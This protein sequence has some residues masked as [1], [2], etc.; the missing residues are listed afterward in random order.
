[1]SLLGSNFLVLGQLT[2]FSILEKCSC[3][4][5][6]RIA[7]EE[8]QTLPSIMSEIRSV[9]VLPII[10]K[11]RTIECRRDREGVVDCHQDDL[12]YK[13]RLKH[14][15]LPQDMLETLIAN[16]YGRLFKATNDKKKR[17]GVNSQPS[18]VKSREET[19][20]IIVLPP[21]QSDPPK[22]GLPTKI[23][24]LPKI[25]KNKVSTE[26]D[27][28]DD[29]VIECSPTDDEPLKSDGVFLSKNDD[30]NSAGSLVYSCKWV[31]KRSAQTRTV[32]VDKKRRGPPLQSF[33]VLI[34]PTKV[35][36]NLLPVTVIH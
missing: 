12:R 16:L 19:P 1:M 8:A 7:G 3:M 27:Q 15:D 20:F 14:P 29:L 28:S 32:V 10:R 5:I 25:T 18:V 6:L 2:T 35:D 33:Q 11:S 13:I 26:A 22:I 17:E 36:L 4:S 31:S 34:D 23:E 30:F 21:D 24:S 9:E